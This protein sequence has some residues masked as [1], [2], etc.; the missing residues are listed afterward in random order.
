MERCLSQITFRL[1]SVALEGNTG[2]GRGLGD[3][4]QELARIVDVHFAS[5]TERDQPGP[6]M[7]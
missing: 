2:I 3:F 7:K 1:A 4:S 5:V 6:K